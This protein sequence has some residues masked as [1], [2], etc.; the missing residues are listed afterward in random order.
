[1]KGKNL[2]IFDRSVDIQQTDLL[3]SFGQQCSTASAQ[4]RCRQAGLLQPRQ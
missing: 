4:L 1:M 3:G 2:P